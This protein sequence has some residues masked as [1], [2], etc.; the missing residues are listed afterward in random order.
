MHL[1][2]IFE[3]LSCDTTSEGGYSDKI[4]VNP[5]LID[6]DD[7]MFEAFSDEAETPSS[8]LCCTDFDPCDTPQHNT[9]CRSLYTMPS[10][11]ALSFAAGFGLGMALG[12]CSFLRHPLST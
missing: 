6:A 12:T 5:L 8:V 10:S 3:D 11:C 7:F 9:A 1:S 2:R 4:E